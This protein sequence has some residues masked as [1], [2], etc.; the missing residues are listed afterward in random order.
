MF[1][2]KQHIEGFLATES[3]TGLIDEIKDFKVSLSSD[4]EEQEFPNIKRLGKRS[5]FL[6]EK[7]LKSTK[8]I[9]ILASNIQL[10]N[11]LKTTGEIDYLIEY[12]NQ[13]IHLELA[14]KFYLL[15]ESIDPVLSNQW[16]GPNRKDFLHLKVSK[17]KNHQFPIINSPEFKRLNLPVPQIQSLL[18]KAMLFVPFDLNK[19]LPNNYKSCVAGIWLT[20]NH[21]DLLNDN[22]FFIPNKHDW[23]IKPKAQENWKSKQEIINEIKDFHSRQ[24]SPLVWIKS[25]TKTQR[26]FVVW[27]DN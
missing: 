23:F 16:I 18:L 9:N 22:E 8:G 1:S 12:K 17:L 2:F 4:V 3:L 11:E 21:L 24:F 14:T 20:M 25:L 15:D 27:W 26:C 19:Q 7:I 5:E 6:F 10:K 13:I